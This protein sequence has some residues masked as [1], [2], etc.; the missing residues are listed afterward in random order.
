M[1]FKVYSG[2][3]NIVKQGCNL[4]SKRRKITFL[5]IF[6]LLFFL[7]ACGPSKQEKINTKP[8]CIPLP[9][10]L[11]YKKFKHS[12]NNIA[13][14]ILTIHNGYAVLELMNCSQKN[15]L[16]PETNDYRINSEL[17]KISCS[18]G[19]YWVRNNIQRAKINNTTVRALTLKPNES[20]IYFYP[21]RSTEILLLDDT[22]ISFRLEVTDRIKHIINNKNIIGNKLTPATESIILKSDSH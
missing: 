10:F 1:N 5:N 22:R 21:F 16:V 13:L 12:D 3:L 8:E 14:R 11:I 2:A 9:S 6:C 18:L 19:T 17:F 20:I 7:S 15:I 4:M